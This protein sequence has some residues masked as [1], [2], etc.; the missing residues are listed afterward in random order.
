MAIVP[1]S[2]E[3]YAEAHSTAESDVLAALAA[4][5][6]AATKAPGMMT[7]HLEGRFLEMLVFAVQP[8][9][10]VEVGTFTGYGSISMA[11][12][13]PP[14]GRVITCDV[15]EE[16]TAVARKF[17]HDAGV[18][19]RIDFRLGPALDTIATIDEPIGLAFID[20]DKSGY[21]SYFEAI[22]PKLAPHGLIAI[23]NVLWGG[24]VVEPRRDDERPDTQALRQLNDELARDDRI[25]CVMT[26]IR[27]GVTLVRRRT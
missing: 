9:L 16:T 13:L 21:R 19:D 7:G 3:S 15:N 18:A 11:T 8:T 14:D 2:I 25:V 17:A 10:V 24:S 22:L 4:H 27:D 1:E 20:A 5:T 26:T 23:D 6:R 12:A